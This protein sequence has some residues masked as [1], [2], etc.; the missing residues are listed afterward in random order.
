MIM[1]DIQSFYKFVTIFLVA[2][3]LQF[4]DNIPAKDN[5]IY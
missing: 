5:K 4:T 2:G 1:M 3:A